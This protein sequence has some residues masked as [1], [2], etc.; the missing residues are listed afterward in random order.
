MPVL[1]W[2]HLQS[3]CAAR[4]LQSALGWVLL[5]VLPSALCAPPLVLS[6]GT[7]PPYVLP[8]KTGFLDLLTKET[9]RRIGIDA[10]VQVHVASGRALIN[11]NNGIDDG[12]VMRVAGLERKYPSLVMLPERIIG[13]DFVAY[14]LDE[15]LKLADPQT[16]KTNVVGYI[17]GWVVFD[18]LVGDNVNVT[19]VRDADQ[20]FSLL[21]LGRAD[22]ALYERWQGLWLIRHTGT[23]IRLLEPP[24]AQVDMFMYLNEKHRALAGPATAA[25]RGMKRDG[26]YQALYSRAF[27][28]LDGCSSAAR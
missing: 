6:T 17:T 12:L 4:L 25:L 9:F 16:L 26:T 7:A 11:A 27:S 1:A 13:N 28:P 21:R 10:G 20:L 5:L 24:L 15:K 22:I 23:P 19:K 2:S 3:H 14:T 8:D 18:R